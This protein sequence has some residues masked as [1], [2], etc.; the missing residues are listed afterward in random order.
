MTREANKTVLLTCLFVHNSLT[1]RAR[2][3]GGAS[4][5]LRH[6]SAASTDDR[7]PTS[8]AL[9]L[10]LRIREWPLFDPAKRECALTKSQD[11]RRFGRFCYSC[12]VVLTPSPIQGAAFRRPN[13]VACR[14]HQM[15]PMVVAMIPSN[16]KYSRQTGGAVER[17]L[18]LDSSPRVVADT[19]EYTYGA[20]STAPN[21]QARGGSPALREDPPSCSLIIRVTVYSKRRI[22][23]HTSSSTISGFWLTRWVSSADP[24]NH[25][26]PA[27]C[28]GMS[29]TL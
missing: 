17:Q 26:A 27:C 3:G 14:V 21:G 25:G 19:L 5:R 1:Q 6:P 13:L 12:C 9:Q 8:S 11:R 2:R 20:S 23:V 18:V 24:F 22:W 15:V 10:S 4:G 29:C 7:R 16:G 28:D